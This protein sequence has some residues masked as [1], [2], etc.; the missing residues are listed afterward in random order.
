[1]TTFNLMEYRQGQPV[2]TRDGLKTVT[3]IKQIKYKSGP[4][5]VSALINGAPVIWTMDGLL[6]DGEENPGD[7]MMYTPIVYRWARTED[8]LDENPDDDEYTQVQIVA[9]P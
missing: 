6:V 1:M 5:Y 2:K 4:S 9:L 3:D 7:L 8:L